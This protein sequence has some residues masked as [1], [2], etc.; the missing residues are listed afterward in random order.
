MMQ[1]G[2]NQPILLTTSSYNIEQLSNIRPRLCTLHKWSHFDGRNKN[3][4]FLKIQIKLF[5][6]F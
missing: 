4:L 3:F 5:E 2:T 1:S 6:Y